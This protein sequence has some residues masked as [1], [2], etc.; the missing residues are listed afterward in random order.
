VHANSAGGPG[1]PSAL[2]SGTFIPFG[3]PFSGAAGSKG[4]YS[5]AVAVPNG[6][7]G[8]QT[9]LNL[10]ASATGYTKSS[11][12]LN[13]TIGG[14]LTQDFVLPPSSQ[15]GSAIV[16]GTV[17]GSSGPELPAEMFWWHSGNYLIGTNSTSDIPL[18]FATPASASLGLYV[19]GP[20]G[21]HGVTTVW[22]PDSQF[23]GPFVATATP[24]P[25]PTIV[26]QSDNGTY[27]RVNLTYDHSFRLITLM[28]STPVPE[29]PGV[30]LVAALGSAVAVALL[31]ER[32]LRLPGVA[33]I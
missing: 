18:V 14:D 19:Q 22:I 17:T 32:K 15:G 24:G 23:K 27:Y 6:L 12:L 20:E 33:S 31:Y 29:F 16:S 5:I 2:I 30:A 3:F 4:A 21:T 8:L 26:S 11:V 25:N 10:T 28:G 9:T 13:V 7:G 1:I